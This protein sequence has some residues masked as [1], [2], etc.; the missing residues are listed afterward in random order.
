MQTLLNAVYKATKG[1]NIVA[2]SN[3][4]VYDSPHR[5]RCNSEIRKGSH[6]WYV[7]D[8]W[9][10]VCDPYQFAIPFTTWQRGHI[11]V[12]FFLEGDLPLTARKIVNIVA[13][14]LGI[15]LFISSGGI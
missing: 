9:F 10:V 7:R 13:K 5:G 12:D 4:R 11:R 1:L 14:C 15:G 6:C 3:A 8:C 2:D